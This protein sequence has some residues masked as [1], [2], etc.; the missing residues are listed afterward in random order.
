MPANYKSSRKKIQEI[1]DDLRG[2]IDQDA[3][4][5][6]RS[7][8]RELDFRFR[9]AKLRDLNDVELF[10]FISKQMN[11]KKIPLNQVASLVNDLRAAQKQMAGV[12]DNYY[13]DVL[14][15][16]EII[17]LPPGDYEKL[18]AANQ[19]NFN[20]INE[21]TNEA[22][23]SEFQKQVRAGYSYE[24]LRSKLVARSIGDAEAS[25]LANTA[26]AQ[27]DNAYN[28]ENAQQAGIEK[29]IYDGAIVET[30][31]QFCKDRIHKKYT[32]EELGK[33]GN[34]QGLPVLYSLGGHNCTH[35]LTPVVDER[36][37]RKR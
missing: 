37:R 34:G 24:T 31:R 4:A 19:V 30:S 12:W 36:V 20:D 28:A 5:Y 18:L 9:Q 14:G 32:L 2:K 13:T 22:L 8:I 6:K 11:N 25:T 17:T 27:F 21:A 7:I 33:M 1:K 15:E 35:F 10:N 3:L 23:K 26:A 16:G 29:F